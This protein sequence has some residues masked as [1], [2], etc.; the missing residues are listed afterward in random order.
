MTSAWNKRAT[1]D[2][3]GFDKN[4]NMVHDVTVTI[5]SRRPLDVELHW[6][7]VSR[8]TFVFNDDGKHDDKLTGYG[9][10]VVFDDMVLSNIKGTVKPSAD[11]HRIVADGAFGLNGH[12]ES[13][14]SVHH[15]NDSA[16]PV[17]LTLA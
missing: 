10:N 6:D 13:I 5:N 3:L 16:H 9:N 8:V 4:G 12:H 14:S 17:H 1:V 11:A 15:V 2:I 7:K